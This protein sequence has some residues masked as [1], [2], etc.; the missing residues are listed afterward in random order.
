MSLN[1][2]SAEVKP[3]SLDEMLHTQF[4]PNFSSLTLDFKLYH[5]CIY[6]VGLNEQQKCFQFEVIKAE[7]ESYKPTK[8]L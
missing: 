6:W 7:E 2:Y 8:I 3:L 4:C 5:L 1:A